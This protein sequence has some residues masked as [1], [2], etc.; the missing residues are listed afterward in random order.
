MI[1]KRIYEIWINPDPMPDN[2]REYVES[3]KRVMPDYEIVSISLDNVKRNDFINKA[4]E[5]NKYALVSHYARC[6]EIYENGGIYMDLD[7]EA[8]RPF[9]DLLDNKMFAGWEDRLVFN[10]AVF[11]AEAGHPFLKKCLDYMDAYDID[12]PQVEL[13]TGPWMFTK[14]LTPDVTQYPPQYFYPYHYSQQ[15]SP[16]CITPETYAIHHWAHSW[17]KNA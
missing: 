6:Q 16:D 5:R 8:V 12:S 4:I 9:D 1:P 11:G 10:N 17:W 14:L 3:W 2:F 13:H 7:V 15:F